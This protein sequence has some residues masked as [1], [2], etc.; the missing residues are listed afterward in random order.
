M[1]LFLSVAGIIGETVLAGDNDHV[2]R[3][4]DRC[5]KLPISK[6]RVR[7]MEPS[8]RCGSLPYHCSILINVFRQN[9]IKDP[10]WYDV[11]EGDAT[12]FHIASLPG[13][14][15]YFRLTDGNSGKFHVQ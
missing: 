5:I 8:K 1:V 4:A 10:Q 12:M 9:I 11:Q 6:C 14:Q 2:S 15:T 7:Y 13:Q 3:Y